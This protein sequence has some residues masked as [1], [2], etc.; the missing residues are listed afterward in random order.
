MLTLLT[1]FSKRS[2]PAGGGLPTII[3][4]DANEQ[5]SIACGVNWTIQVTWALDFTNDSEY[6]IEVS[7][8]GVGVVAS[9]LATSLG[10]YNHDTG[11]TGDTG[12][13]GVNH[14]ATYTVKLIRISDAQEMQSEVT[15]TLAVET[16]GAC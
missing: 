11:E 3:S 6:E 2:V 14:S 8:N 7:R 15:N 9:G 12:D 5:Q 1:L 13:T 16:G 4:V 10:F